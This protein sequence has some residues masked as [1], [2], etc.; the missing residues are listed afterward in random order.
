MQNA[1][2]LRAGTRSESIAAFPPHDS[3]QALDALT[4][5]PGGFNPA[6]WLAAFERV[7]GGWMVRDCLSLVIR[8]EDQPDAQLD[9]ARRLVVGLTQ[10]HREAIVAHLREREA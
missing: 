9:A 8:V 2:I 4:E 6:E 3:G 7:G 1:P 10:A 5:A